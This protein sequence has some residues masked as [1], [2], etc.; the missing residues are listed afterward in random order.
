MGGKRLPTAK[1]GE[2]LGYLNHS[3]PSWRACAMISIKMNIEIDERRHLEIDLPKN[4]KP[5][6]HEL[7]LIL[8]EAQPTSKITENLNRFMG[9]IPWKIDGLEFQK[10]IRSEW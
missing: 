4:V 2:K 9:S 5:G 6:K 3:W 1:N 8:D 7:T 10:K